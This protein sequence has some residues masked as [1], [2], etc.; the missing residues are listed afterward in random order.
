MVRVLS[1]HDADQLTV[2]PQPPPRGRRLSAVAVA[3]GTR[4]LRLLGVGITVAYLL[5]YLWAIRHLVITGGRSSAFLDSPSVQ[6][7]PDWRSRVFDEVAPFNY[8]PV[9]A[10][11]PIERVQLFLSPVNVAIGAL[12]GV[13]V[14]LNT[15]L[16]ITAQR[17]G[18]ICTNTAAGFLGSIPALFTGFAC[19]VPTFA[20]ALGAQATALA[21]G[22]RTWLFP[23]A[24]AILVITLWWSAGRSARALPVA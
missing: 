6:V 13:L 19:C 18:R 11:Y 22:V 17:A 14:A 15:L 5:V 1:E 23:L 12:L 24:V 3:L 2:A 4:R 20:L 8:E 21:V 9:V 7:V 16:A 10:I